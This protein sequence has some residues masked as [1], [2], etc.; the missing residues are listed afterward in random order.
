MKK[1]INEAFVVSKRFDKKGNPIAFIDPTKPENNNTF[2]YKDILKDYG[3]KW[4]GENKYWFWYIGK[5]KE[6]WNNVYHKFIEPALKKIHSMENVGED[7]SKQSLIKSIENVLEELNNTPVGSDENVTNNDKFDVKNRLQKFKEMLINIDNDEDFKKTMR[8]ILAFKNLLGHIYSFR[9]TLLI[10]IQRPDAQM[11]KSELNWNAVN[12]EVVDKSK[13]IL[14]IAPARSAFKSY[15]PDE[16]KRIIINFLNSLGKKSEDELTLGEKEKLR[17]LLRGKLVKNE[18]ELAPVYDITDTKQIEG[19]ENLVKDVDDFINMKWYVD[20]YKTS[21]ITPL[22]NALLKFADENGISISFEEKD[23][24]ILKGA[25]G[26]S[27][28][29]KIYVLKNDG[30]DVGITKTLAH[31]IFH[32]LLHQKYL[33]QK[34][35]KYAAYFVGNENGRGLVEQQAELSAW[36]LLASFGFDLKTTSINYVAIWGADKDAMVRVFDTIANVVN[37]MIDYVNGVI[38]TFASTNV[39]LSEVENI[40]KKGKHITPMDVA[41]VLGVTDEYKEVLSDLR[42]KINEHFYRFVKRKL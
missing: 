38:T 40:V 8:S 11:V 2:K 27:I 26:A 30:N 4:D 7:D 10:Y 23:S 42:N 15:T 39:K 19:K 36:M 24:K 9:N 29:G 17:V 1:N 32:E 22:Y 25:R 33:S 14:I 3:A 41:K 35:S 31:E 5:N 13:R 18:F 6:Q 20:D 16:K 21:E 28:G 34:N 37:F 12:R